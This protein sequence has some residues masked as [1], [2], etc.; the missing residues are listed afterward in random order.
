MRQ[1]EP[2]PQ[3]ISKKDEVKEVVVSPESLS[4][5]PVLQ[6]EDLD[7]EFNMQ[8]DLQKQVKAFKSGKPPL[9]P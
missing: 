9:I 7:F 6:V 4:E 5:K 8:T 2:F 1:E 3:E